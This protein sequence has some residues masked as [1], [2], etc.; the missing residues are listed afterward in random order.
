MFPRR[1]LA[2][3]LLSARLCSAADLEALGIAPASP[4]YV[5]RLRAAGG[6]R[7]SGQ[8][9]SGMPPMAQVARAAPDNLFGS[10]ATTG[11][12]DKGG[13]QGFR[14]KMMR[15]QEA[16]PFAD[17]SNAPRPPAPAP[18]PPLPA[19][20]GA[21][22]R[23][24]GSGG[25]Q[26]RKG[27]DGSK[28][29]I[30]ATVTTVSSAGLSRTPPSLPLRGPEA[31]SSSAW[32]DPDHP[33]PPL[34]PPSLDGPQEDGPADYHAGR[35]RSADA[36]V[37]GRER[38]A[39]PSGRITQLLPKAERG[40]ASNAGYLAKYFTQAKHNATGSR[41]AKVGGA[42]SEL[43]AGDGLV[44]TGVNPEPTNMQQVANHFTIAPLGLQNRHAEVGDGA[45]SA[46]SAEDQT[47][48]P[49]SAN[50]APLAKF[51]PSSE[52]SAHR[53]ASLLTNRSVALAS[54]SSRA[55]AKARTP[56]AGM[57]AATAAGPLPK[58]SPPRH[59]PFRERWMSFAT[60]IIDRMRDLK[61][62]SASFRGS[63][64][65]ELMRYF[66]D[67]IRVFVSSGLPTGIDLS[68]LKRLGFGSLLT[69]QSRA[70]NWDSLRERTNKTMSCLFDTSDS[71][72]ESAPTDP[73]HC[74]FSS[75]AVGGGKRNGLDAIAWSMRIPVLRIATM[76]AERLR[77]KVPDSSAFPIKRL[78]EAV[79]NSAKSMDGGGRSGR[80]VYRDT[81]MWAGLQ[82]SKAAMLSVGAKSDNLVVG[83]RKDDEKEP[84]FKGARWDA[85]KQVV[86]SVVRFDSAGGSGAAGALAPELTVVAK[87][88][89]V[90]ATAGKGDK[91]T[92][93]TQPE[94]N[95][96]VMGLMLLL[97]RKVIFR[98][99]VV[100][101]SA[102]DAEIKPAGGGR[103]RTQASC[104]PVPLVPGT[105]GVEVCVGRAP[106]PPAAALTGSAGLVY[107]SFHTP[108]QGSEHVVMPGS[109]D[110]TDV[111]FPFDAL[112][113]I[114][115]V[116]GSQLFGMPLLSLPSA[117]IPVHP[118]MTDLLQQRVS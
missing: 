23:A 71:V 87:F 118:T 27:S 42:A 94:S 103:T 91:V 58:P 104:Y 69:F 18:P 65:D 54:D 38:S 46:N 99:G 16:R 13:D 79:E 45:A 57:H 115:L 11:A 41:R 19:G 49:S 39:Q 93:E 98:R 96:H 85:I 55:A 105:F 43:E 83:G 78:L 14:Q 70:V 74:V 108:G 95:V 34:A 51:L 7:G 89:T 6:G 114:R 3:I 76:S 77:D 12:V 48:A 26:P 40:M 109:G 8:P 107:R 28:P 88:T 35:A 101:P 33:A 17:A 80:S 53:Q 50:K 47:G 113:G 36:D 64:L 32:N 86:E 52:P 63:D 84:L 92:R 44:H 20:G 82:K 4:R 67:L 29:M 31:H 10:V 102:S 100:V 22:A 59:N 97:D 60:R 21:N 112:I 116:M 30:P 9:V 72:R 24:T 1:A 56:A 15:P 111:T 68:A 110:Y 37:P 66:E 2:L 106:S 75:S 90:L 25:T 73:D 61:P 81:A 117:T 62:P 5:A